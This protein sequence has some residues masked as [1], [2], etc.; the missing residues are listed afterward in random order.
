M[1]GMA[2]KKFIDGLSITH[3]DRANHN[4]IE[5]DQSFDMFYLFF[6]FF[7]SLLGY[8]RAVSGTMFLLWFLDKIPPTQKLTYLPRICISCMVPSS[9]PGSARRIP[10]VQA[11]NSNTDSHPGYMGLCP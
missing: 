11:L 10:A 2:Y 1:S 5:C 3:K 8:W 6:W 9:V 4:Y 7:T